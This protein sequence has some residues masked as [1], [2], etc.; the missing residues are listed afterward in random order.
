MVSYSRGETCSGRDQTWMQAGPYPS[1]WCYAAA[2]RPLSCCPVSSKH[3]PTKA[4]ARKATMAVGT[5]SG[6]G[7]PRHATMTEQLPRLEQGTSCCTAMAGLA[8][9]C[10]QGAARAYGLLPLCT[11]LLS[12]HQQ[13]HCA[14][15]RRH[16]LLLQPWQE[17]AQLMLFI[18]LHCLM[19][20]ATCF[21]AQ[22]V[23]CVC[24]GGVGGGGGGGVVYIWGLH[25]S[26]V[27]CCD[28]LL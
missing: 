6:S 21:V 27:C 7:Q 10:P 3:A 20:S 8:F 25:I 1:C 22:G 19:P 16:Q 26:T 4:S 17:E 13:C 14:G 18:R 15:S 12:A 9:F 5:R 24:G 11:G 28:M 23:V 2:V